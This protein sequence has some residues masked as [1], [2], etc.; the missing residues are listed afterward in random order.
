MESKKPD[1]SGW[2]TKS[3]IKCTD[4]RTIMKNAF[5]H[6]DKY[7][8][9]LV[10][11]HDRDNPE[12]IL[13]HTYLE[14]RAF[15]I[16]AKGYFDKD[17]PNSEK[18]KKLVHSGAINALSIFATG[19]VQRGLQVYHGVI[20]EVSLVPKGAN[21]GAVIE[22]IHLSHDD[23]DVLQEA[24]IYTGLE[25]EHEDNTQSED[26]EMADKEEKPEDNKTVQDVLDSLNEEQMTAVNYLLGNA[27]E[28]D[29]EDIE[30]E[31][32]DE[33]EEP[34]D[35]EESK[36]KEPALAHS[37]ES[38]TNNENLKN[39]ILEHVDKNI[40]KGLE[41]MSRNVFEKYGKNDE[42]NEDTIGNTK[43]TH[44]DFAEFITKARNNNTSLKTVLEHADAG[45]YGIT[46]ISFLFPDAKTISNTP[47][48]ISRRM[49]W[50]SKVLSGTKHSPFA[51]V[52]TVHADITEPEAR[53]RGYIKNTRKKE[54]VFKLLKRTTGPT[55]I[56][57]KQRLD[58]DDILDIT[59]FDMVN[60][61]MAEM[62]LMI[63]EEIA[64]AILIGDGRESLDP[65][66]IRD[67]EGSPQGDGIRSIANDDDLYAIPRN[68]P[69]NTSPNDM[70]E[71][72]IRSRA[73]YRGSGSP[74]LYISENAL[75]DVLLMKDKMGRYI[76]DTQAVLEDKLRVAEI[77][78]VGLFDEQPDL[79][80]IM[81]NLQDYTIGANKGGQLTNFDDFD[82]DFNQHV[83]LTE[84]RI[85]GAL[86]KAYSAVVGRRA[87]G[88]QAFPTAP[89][90]NGDTNEITIPVATGVEYYIE[91][92]LVNGIVE[93]IEATEVVARP[94]DGYYIASGS[95]TSW[96][97]TV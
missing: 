61:L 14:D 18:A 64:R 5:S 17:N 53:A 59:D 97:F 47:E 35:D 79:L 75:T 71:D 34:E 63:E 44:G 72:I 38:E 37:K 32:S 10:W 22:N 74:T 85:S 54:E 67:P 31:E 69:A 70:V 7:T 89:S 66:K 42:S 23:G 62:R 15:G 88:I 65:D 55:T 6:Q 16:Y 20:E 81:V 73:I 28:I 29:L 21:P 25:L 1:F 76:Y 43:M 90:Y 39:E 95:T 41:D 48:F 24:I 83:Y 45:E 12:N 36:N 60:W 93:I 91:D 40:K 52:K 87:Q 57:K 49:E 92:E 19:L 84:T 33:S 3:D 11:K 80:Y 27:L 96:N 50:V 78:P 9:P 30:E 58:R 77:V 94:A 51:K 56:Y 4:G 68:L 46:D 86:T 13:G 26:S 2:A 8:V 82:I